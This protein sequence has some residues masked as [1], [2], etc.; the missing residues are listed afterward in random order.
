MFPYNVK[1]ENLNLI[2]LIIYNY[3]FDQII[4]MVSRQSNY[5]W[6]IFLANEVFKKKI[7]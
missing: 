7:K 1:D 6:T 4:Y 5:I 2:I 3:K